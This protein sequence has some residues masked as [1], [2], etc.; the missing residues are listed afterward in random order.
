MVVQAAVRAAAAASDDVRTAA[1]ALSPPR[2]FSN[3]KY[4]NGKGRLRRE[5]LGGDGRRSML[6]RDLRD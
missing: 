6:A 5:L 2:E 1:T 3:L 4:P